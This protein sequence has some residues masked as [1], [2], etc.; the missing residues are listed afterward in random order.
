MLLH[1]RTNTSSAYLVNLRTVVHGYCTGSVLLSLVYC[2]FCFYPMR[3]LGRS[4]DN[5]VIAKKMPLMFC[6][7]L[8]KD[9]LQGKP[10]EYFL[11]T[12]RVRLGGGG[13]RAPM[14]VVKTALDRTA[15]GT[16]HSA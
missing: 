1:D 11:A 16:G 8:R 12:G 2:V 6:L 10:G 4:V 15:I 5:D 7:N 13:P 9:Q 14:L 3:F